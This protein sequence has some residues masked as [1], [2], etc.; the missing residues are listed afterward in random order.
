MP[1]HHSGPIAPTHHCFDDAVDFFE[2][3]EP[4]ALRE[5][6]SDYRIVHAICELRA[7]RFAH[8][9]VEQRN[10]AQPPVIWQA[11]ILE[12]GRRAYYALLALPFESVV[13]KRYTLDEAL[14]H[15]KRS[16]NSG[17]WDA[18]T[19]AL[20]ELSKGAIIGAVD[21]EPIGGFGFVAPVERSR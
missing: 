21:I 2:L 10:G 3:I 4:H 7:E 19:A 16:G 9:W 13:A 8:A 20:C 17:P 11:G 12:D 5:C 6:H 1:K 14:G 18:E 15:C